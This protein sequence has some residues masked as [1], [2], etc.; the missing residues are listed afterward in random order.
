MP[1]N[2][3]EFVLEPLMLNTCVTLLPLTVSRFDPGP[4]MVT[5]PT[6]ESTPDVNVIVLGVEK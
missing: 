3:T 1:D 2:E 4:A 6:D 5:G